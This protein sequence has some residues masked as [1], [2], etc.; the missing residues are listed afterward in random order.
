MNHRIRQAANILWQGGVIAYAT[1]GVWGLG[2]LPQNLEAIQRILDIKQRAADKGLI[3]VAAQAAQLEPYLAPIHDQAWK[4]MM[5]SWPGPVTWV[6]PAASWVPAPI[7]GGR[8]TVAVRVSAHPVVRGL[9]KAADSALVSTSANRSGKHP[10]R[11]ALEARMGFGLLV[12]DIVPGKIGASAGPTEIR[13]ALSGKV[14]RKAARG[15][16]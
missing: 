3:L 13:D 1:E 7:T 10:A 15:A 14:L 4:R 9:C 6:V 5:A 12:D 16:Q 2:C 11:S 8:K